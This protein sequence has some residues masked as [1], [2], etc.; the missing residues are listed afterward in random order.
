VTCDHVH[1]QAV[2]DAIDALAPGGRLAIISFHSL[3]DRVVKRAFSVACG[4]PT[5]EDEHRLYGPDKFEFLDQLAARA[6]AGLV[7]RKPVV[8]D[9]QEQRANPRSRSAKLRVIQ[10]VK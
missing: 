9:E 5:P 6:V 3:E 4:K 1:T 7:T 2:P 8:A 10:R